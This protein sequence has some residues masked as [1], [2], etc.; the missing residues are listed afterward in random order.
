MVCL[1]VTGVPAL[2]D[3]AGGAAST[4]APRD[5]QAELWAAGC[6]ACH[7]DAAAGGFPAL[8][9]RD[10]GE[11]LALLLRQRAGAADT[12][13]MHQHAKG[14]SEAELARIAAALASRPKP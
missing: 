14:F 6:A 8:A 13:I 7:S 1:S 10:A 2:A 5:R 4:V 9:G 12:T 3:S 11:L